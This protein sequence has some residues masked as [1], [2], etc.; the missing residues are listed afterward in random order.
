M[1]TDFI[2]GRTVPSIMMQASF[3]AAAACCGIKCGPAF[4]DE[5]A[6]TLFEEKFHS[7]L[8]AG[9]LWVR[10]EPAAWRIDDSGLVLR[11][12]PGYL[13]AESNNAKNILLREIHSAHDATVVAEV[14]VE[15][16]PQ[17]QYE[18]AGLIW[19]VDD[20]NYIALF[21]E[22]MGGKA[23]L[24]MVVEKAGKGQFAVATGDTKAVRLRFKIAGDEITGQVRET[25]GAEW[26][27]VGKMKLPS[28]E[29]ARIGIMSGGAPKNGERTARFS[30]FRIFRLEK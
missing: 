5:R 21:V 18:H 22:S 7:K 28:T 1:K 23:K 14:D 13:H 30:G 15:S 20:D 17:I 25:G 8:T 26:R 16:A 6:V 11:V 9:W 19:Y 10:E 4:A 24:Q 12:Q 29:K 3:L 2:R 27:V